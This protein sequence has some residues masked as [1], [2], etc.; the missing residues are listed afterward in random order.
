MPTAIRTRMTPVVIEEIIKRRVAK[1]LEAYEVNRNREPIMESGDERE[2]DNGDGNGNDNE[3]GGEN[4]NG[5]GLGG[6]NRDENPNVNVGGVVPVAR[7][8]T[9]QDFLKCLTLIFKG[10]EGVVGLTRWFEKMKTVFYI[11]NCPHKYQVKYASCT[12]Q[13][14]AL[15][16]QNSHKRTVGTDAAYAMSWKGHYKSDCPK[17]KNQNRRNKAANNEARGRAYALV[18]GD[19]NLEFNVVTGTFLLN[20]HYARILFD[21]GADKSFVSTTFSALID[22]LPTALDNRYPLPR[23]DNLFDQLQGSSV[24]SKIDLR[25]RY[26][27]L[28]VQEEDISKTTFKTRYGH[29]EFQSKEDHEERLK[30][31]LELLKKEELYIKFS[32]CEF[33]LL[34]LQFLSHVID[35]KGIHVDPDKIESIKDWAS[36][37]TPTEICQFLGLVGYY[38]RFIENLIV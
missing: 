4:G 17:L 19:G 16:W 15:T 27:Q 29:Y 32:K 11:S 25:S 18:G 36:S 30:L 2:D 23:I 34:K 6:G 13:N 35:S 22:I 26:H 20:N 3:D 5:N 24:Y 21:S 7:E 10:T 1:A 14:G 31:I 12:L 8:C 37:K 38:R 33:W 9:Y 28:R